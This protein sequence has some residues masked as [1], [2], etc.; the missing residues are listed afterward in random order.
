MGEATPDGD[1]W[2]GGAVVIA[3]RLCDLAGTNEILCSDVVRRILG[4][5]LRRAVRAEGHDA[6]QGPLRARR[7]VHEVLWRQPAADAAGEATAVPAI[8]DGVLPLPAPL[9]AVDPL[10]FVGRDAE[11]ARLRTAW[12]AVV[13]GPRP[14]LLIVTGEAGIGKSALARHFALARHDE[15][16]SV[17]FG[18]CDADAV[19]PFQPVAEAIRHLPVREI[20]ANLPSS[21]RVEVARL[22]PGLLGADPGRR[23]AGGDPDLDRFLLFD[24]VAQLLRAVAERGPFVFVV[25]DIH[26]AGDATLLLLRHLLLLDV[27]IPMLVLA[28]VRDGEP[29][30]HGLGGL[31]A[32]LRRQDTV[33]RV[34]LGGLDR[35][36]V[37]L[38]VEA[39]GYEASRARSVYERSEG[40]PFF[41]RAL[42]DHL[43]AGGPVETALPEG[44]LDVLRDRLDRLT[45][46]ARSVL[47]AGAIVGSTFD[48]TLVAEV[49]GLDDAV[50]ADAVDEVV[51]ARLIEEVPD[52]PGALVFGHQLVRQSLVATASATRRS[53]LHHQVAEALERRH[54]SGPGRWAGDLAHH[55]LASGSRASAAQVLA[56]SMAAATVAMES[57][58]YELAAERLEQALAVAA[59]RDLP[60]VDRVPA[61]LTLSRALGA[62][63]TC[64]R[65]RAIAAEAIEAARRAGHSA[66]Q[67]EAALAFAGTG[68]EVAVADV[69][70]DALLLE[71]C[72]LDGVPTGRRVEL[73]AR[74]AELRSGAGEIDSAHT[75]ARDA[76]AT[77]AIEGD[78]A[79]TVA[80]AW[81]AYHTLAGPDERSERQAAA[82]LLT[83]AAAAV[84]D[85]P[86]RFRTLRVQTLEL[87]ERGDLRG[88]DDCLAELVTLVDRL[89]QPRNGWL[90]GTTQ[91]ARALAGG[92]LEGAE[93]AS[94]RAFGVGVDAQVANAMAVY[95]MQLFVIRREQGRLS[96]LAGVAQPAVSQREL[97]AVVVL[98][99]ALE[100]NLGRRGAPVLERLTAGFF[101]ELP[102]DAMWSGTLATGAELLTVIDDLDVARTIKAQ[103]LVA[104]DRHIVMGYG[105]LLLGPVRRVLGD[106]CGHL[107]EHDEAIEHLSAA[108]DEADAGEAVLAATY[109]RL[110][111]AR[112][113]QLRA[114]HGDLERAQEMVT[115]AR[116][117]AIDKD[118]VV[119]A[120][121]ARRMTRKDG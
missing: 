34:V 68:A 102:R 21:V 63:G 121:R 78:P 20:I 2:Q 44:V 53:L 59:V 62:G 116:D 101:D 79:S 49:C 74:L 105:A 119:L 50:V 77:A 12:D 36:E 110:S 56:A 73:L 95:A 8:G 112:Q 83:D 51:D 82:V 64:D 39:T 103:L 72:D 84:A 65:A 33:E 92:D 38:L 4:Q 75:F 90:V 86:S 47:E 29:D 98:R 43:E 22:A 18:R 23:A 91:A 52:Q 99:A 107:R 94:G 67:A 120:D 71:A 57:Y 106:V 81:A 7:A 117:A 118:L 104:A 24:G 85:E 35:A 54:G 30:E 55:R 16:T 40:N 96:E 26:W 70:V 32:H 14:R 97:P 46:A 115:V 88:V 5:R 87:A 93:H 37:D 69:E 17:L 114:G 41:V 60:P 76:L 31:V 109:A 9:G 61:L 27:P 25:D 13:A 48:A 58:A 108:V 1:D 111:L 19:V 28:T 42:L 100:V 11:L 113:L 66:W 3:K 45:P 89:R 15:G 6:A 80:A 10:P